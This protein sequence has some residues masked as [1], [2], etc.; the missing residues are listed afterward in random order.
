LML[1]VA[2][3]GLTGWRG[4]FVGAFVLASAFPPESVSKF[5]LTVLRAIGDLYGFPELPGV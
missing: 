3:V 1:R 4:V 2:S 5:L